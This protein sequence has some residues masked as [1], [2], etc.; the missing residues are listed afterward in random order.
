MQHLKVS[1]M[2]MTGD[3]EVGDCCGSENFMIAVSLI[4]GQSGDKH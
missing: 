4:G 1:E 3:G 2:G